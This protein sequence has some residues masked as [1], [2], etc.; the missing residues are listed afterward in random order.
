MYS[1]KIFDHAPAL[2]TAIKQFLQNAKE[3]SDKANVPHMDCMLP[4]WLIREDHYHEFFSNE[5]QRWE[6]HVR[7]ILFLSGKKTS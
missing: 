4:L 2:K 7:Y 1:S 6:D 3:N 5:E